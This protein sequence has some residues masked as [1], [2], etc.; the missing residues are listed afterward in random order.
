MTEH[1]DG[2]DG[3]VSEVLALCLCKGDKR[4]YSGVKDK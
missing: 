4:V 2:L 1:G 3:F